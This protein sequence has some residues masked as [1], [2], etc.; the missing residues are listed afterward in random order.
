MEVIAGLG[1]SSWTGG[2]DGTYGSGALT[3]INSS[4][5]SGLWTVF[6]GVSSDVYP[7]LYDLELSWSDGSSSTEYTQPRSVWVLEEWPETLRVAHVSD[8]HLPYGA[9]ILATYVYEANLVDADMIVVTGDIVDVETI[10]SSW[11]YLQD[12][13]GRLGIP[14]FLLPGN[15]DYT[16]GS[17][18]F[19]K[20][21][22][23]KNY[24][25]VIGDFLFMALDSDGGGYIGQEQLDW[26]ESVLAGNP[27][28][29]KFMG[30]H[31]SLLSSEFE[32]DGGAVKGGELE[33]DWTDIEAL[34]DVMYFTW[35]ENIGL[36][37]E[38]LRIIQTYDVKLVMSGHV[39]RDIIYVLNGENYFV[40]TGACGGG[41]PTGYEGPRSRLI[42][43]DSDGTIRLDEY[44]LAGLFDPPNAIPTGELAYYYWGAN[45]GSG[46]AVSARV[47]NGLEMALED[48]SLEFLVSSENPVGAYSFYPSDPGSYAVVETDAGHLFV[49]RVDVSA[50]G[51]YDLTLAVD[52][53]GV[54]PSVE[55]GFP[56]EYLEGAL[57][58]VT[59]SLTD[60]GWGVM[61]VGASYSLDGG[62]S[63]TEFDAAVSA[64]VNRDEYVVNLQ[65]VILA[66]DVDVSSAP[67]GATLMVRVEATDFAGNRGSSEESY[68]LG[69]ASPAT[70][71][72]SVDSSPVSGVTVTVDGVVYET[73]FEAE[74]VE[75]SHTVVVSDE[76][77][78]EG[79][80]YTFTGWADGSADLERTVDLSGDTDLEA[81]Y[82]ETA[83]EEPEPES[84]GGGIPI[85]YA[86]VAVGL[87]L[88]VVMLF[89]FRRR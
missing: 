79:V 50:G 65:D 24:S 64:I 70:Y 18:L 29:V 60:S 14:I 36:A 35:G 15:H 62:S 8:F 83:A 26:A 30:F 17:V 86:S 9:D 51:V 68:D 3:L 21:G 76:I 41:G 28:K 45:D 81:L 25:V 19:Q 10:A 67:I 5:S 57:V 84:P 37:E 39:H 61:D 40:T 12:I 4:Y 32:D 38:L 72:L 85:P 87:L 20:Y 74:L 49:V 46:E 31:H 66:L 77:T 59:V 73:L 78:V 33:G 2:L 42:E 56:D 80:D 89:L 34:R 11:N 7:A 55:I 58:D 54:E 82:E 71:T 48:A 43:L 6:F 52:A 75:G 44:A 53:D 47:M 63:W 13:T 16:S 23:L 1:A 88:G 27:G 69:D 22:G